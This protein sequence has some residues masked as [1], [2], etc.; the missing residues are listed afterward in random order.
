MG[1]NTKCK[2]LGEICKLGGGEIKT[3]P[4]G[5]QLHKHDYREEG[6]PVIMP[7]NIING[8]VSENDIARIGQDD[9]DRLSRHKLKPGDIVYGRRGDIGRH[10][11]IKNREAGWLCGT[12]CLRISLGNGPV[13]PLYL[14]YF[15][16]W[17]KIIDWIRNHAVGATM[18][19]LNTSILQSVEVH[20][21][22]ISTQKKIATVLSAYDDLIE[23][24]TRRI[25]IL[26][27]MA[28]RI[29]QEWFVNFRFPGHEKVKLVDSELGKIP[30]SWEIV[31]VKSILK[32]LKNGTVYKLK[33]VHYTG[34][35]IV[36]DQSRSEF[37]GFH[38]NEADHKASANNPIVI[39]GD[40]TCKMQLMV[41][42][43]SLGPNTIAFVS[44]N[45]IS[46]YYLYLLVNG[47]VETREYKRH[48][49]ELTSKSIPLADKNLFKMFETNMKPYFSLTELL[50]EKNRNLRQTRDL[51][52]PKL[53]SGEID[54]SGFPEQ[55]ELIAIN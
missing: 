10:A 22:L 2:S 17:Q 49:N 34:N 11:F 42:P 45:N 30:S 27:E 6:T 33:D 55:K 13:D 32:R 37:L 7:K 50:S 51:L 19:N 1:S 15:L 39:F 18:P 12:G 31:K 54:V 40:H 43:F 26:E 8:Q 9:V 3:G 28:K 44:S 53:I 20:Y 52:L 41:R 35:V 29:Y 24:N 14:H 47:L 46:I 36:I 21:P 48:W 38:S 23:N 25:A 16:N 5:S 4:F